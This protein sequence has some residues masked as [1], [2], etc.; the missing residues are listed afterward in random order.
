MFKTM[1][2]PCRIYDQ[3]YYS[4]T[5]H[6]LYAGKAAPGCRPEVVTVIIASLGSGLVPETVNVRFISNSISILV[7]FL[8]SLLPRSCQQL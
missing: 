7:P 1:P 2:V 6:L 8:L 3:A 5:A 4:S